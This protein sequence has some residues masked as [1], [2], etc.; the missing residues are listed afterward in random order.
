MPAKALKT[1]AKKAGESLVTAEKYWREASRSYDK[2]PEGVSDKWAYIMGTVKKR[3]GLE[4]IDL[5]LCGAP[6]EVVVDESV[7]DL[8]QSLNDLGTVDGLDKVDRILITATISEIIKVEVN[9]EHSD[10]VFLDETG[11]VAIRRSF[12]SKLDSE[13]A[14]GFSVEILRKLF[15]NVDIDYA[16]FLAESF[17]PTEVDVDSDHS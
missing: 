3:L 8:D 1:M 12:L 15:P 10:M 16:K 17:E 2:S 4:S 11:T 7:G 14:E 13:L 6:A 5:L 9:R